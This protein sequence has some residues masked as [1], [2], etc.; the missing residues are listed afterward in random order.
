M[1]IDSGKLFPE[2]VSLRAVADC[3]CKSLH[4][5]FTQLPQTLGKKK[6][7]VN[8]QS[9]AKIYQGFLVLPCFRPKDLLLQLMRLRSLCD[10]YVIH[11][12]RQRQRRPI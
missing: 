2:E 3:W 11:E 6:R 8:G 1:W 5:S 10:C 9:L 12:E 4:V 7:Q